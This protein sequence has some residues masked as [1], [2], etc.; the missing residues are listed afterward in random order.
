V[1]E[2][3]EKQDVPEIDDDIFDYEGGMQQCIS[4]FGK[5]ALSGLPFPPSSNS[6]VRR[7]LEYNVNELVR[8][9]RGLNRKKIIAERELATLQAENQ[10]KHERLNR[11]VLIVS[12]MNCVCKCAQDGDF[13]CKQCHRVIDAKALAKEI[14]EERD[15]ALDKMIDGCRETQ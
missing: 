9:C 6:S 13:R 3:T 15:A 5:N 1:T 10:R 2:P 12:K 8:W 4:Q 7:R 14:L 11:L